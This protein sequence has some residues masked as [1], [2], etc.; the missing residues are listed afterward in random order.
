MQELDSS[1]NDTEFQLKSPTGGPAGTLDVLNQPSTHQLDDSPSGTEFPEIVA[2][3][4]MVGADG[5]RGAAL[6][7]WLP[8]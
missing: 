5:R 4:C 2:V 1:Q 6:R 8:P 3:G 7:R